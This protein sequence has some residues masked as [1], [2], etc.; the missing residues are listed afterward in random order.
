[1]QSLIFLDCFVRRESKKNLWG[2][3][4]APLGKGRVK[5]LR[6]GNFNPPQDF[7]R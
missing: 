1:M 4:S 7:S 2:V 6:E 3:D 5:G